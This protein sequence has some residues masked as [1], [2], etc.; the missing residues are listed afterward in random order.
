M[1]KYLIAG[2]W[3]M[4]GSMSQ[5]NILVEGIKEGAKAYSDV[6]ILVLPTF[7]HL[8]QVHQLINHSNI[9]LGAQNLYLSTQGAFTGEVS[10]TMLAELGCQYV[11]VGHSERRS[12]FQ[13]DLT[14]VAKKFKAALEAKLI[15]ILC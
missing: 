11:L 5:I 13:E 2:N 9:L 12:I 15:P 3:K 14:L 6:D 7:V 10:G 8:A 4:H 1:R